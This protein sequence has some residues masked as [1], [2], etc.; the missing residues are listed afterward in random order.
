[1]AGAAT[2]HLGNELDDSGPVEERHAAPV[3]KSKRRW[4]PAVSE[5]QQTHTFA[6][7]TMQAGD[8]ETLFPPLLELEYQHV[9]TTADD[10]TITDAEVA[11]ARYFEVEEGRLLVKGKRCLQVNAG[12]L[13]PP[14]FFLKSLS[15]ARLLT[16]TLT[17]TLTP[18]ALIKGTGVVGIVAA[19]LGAKKV[20]LAD[21]SDK[22][23]FRN[24]DRYHTQYGVRT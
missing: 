21:V 4:V 3:C 16:L 17:L 20:Q 18:I 7:I 6:Y 15:L 13:H 10:A 19:V 14:A 1:M 23:L 22:L 5:S 11:L 24:A 8:D 9:A 2:T 12:D